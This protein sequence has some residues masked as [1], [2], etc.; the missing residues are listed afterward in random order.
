MFAPAYG[1]EEDAASGSACA[2]L[3]GCLAGRLNEREGTFTWRVEQGVAMGRPSLLEASAEKRAGR[4]VKLKVGGHSV[5]VGEGS[6]R[7]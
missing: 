5:I 7:T 4:A 2:A 3:A 6:M 1:I